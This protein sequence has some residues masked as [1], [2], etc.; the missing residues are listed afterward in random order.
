MSID[1]INVKYLRTHG[2]SYIFQI[3]VPS[4]PNGTHRTVRYFHK[5]SVKIYNSKRRKRFF[6]PRSCTVRY[7]LM[8]REL[9]YITA[10]PVVCNIVREPVKLTIIKSYHT[11]VCIFIKIIIFL[12]LQVPLSYIHYFK[13]V[14]PVQKTLPI[15]C[16]I[17]FS[18]HS[19]ICRTGKYFIIIMNDIFSKGIDKTNSLWR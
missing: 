11:Y 12:V 7:S 17:M 18:P 19:S 2:H 16:A 3:I 14:F 13:S 4:L 10:L 15:Y 9:N 6:S 8:E 5:K 1:R